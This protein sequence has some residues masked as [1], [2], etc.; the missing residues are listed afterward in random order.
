MVAKGA[1]AAATPAR[2]RLSSAVAADPGSVKEL[3]PATET[4]DRTPATSAGMLAW[5]ASASAISA[6]VTP[7]T[8][9]ANMDC[10][11]LTESRNTATDASKLPTSMVAVKPTLGTPS[12][13]SPTASPTSLSWTAGPPGL[14]V[15][16]IVPV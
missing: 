5:P 2:S 12:K 13:S 9:P 3:I 16:E 14:N 11:G 1:K 6:S 8:E 4:C 7:L 10:A 15:N